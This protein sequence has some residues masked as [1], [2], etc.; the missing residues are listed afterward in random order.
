MADVVGDVADVAA[1]SDVAAADI[2]ATAAAAAIVLAGGRATRL[3]GT[4]KALLRVQGRP[5][6][7]RV[8]DA[9]GEAGR[10]V[11]AI[12]GPPDEIAQ[13]LHGAA[14][15]TAGTAG[16]VRIVGTLERERYGGPAVAVAA[17]AAALADRGVPRNALVDVL[18]CDFV[19]P[20]EVVA[21]LDEACRVAPLGQAAGVVLV[22]DSGREQWLAARVRLGALTAA[23]AGAEADASLRHF[24]A[25]L[26]LRHAP[27]PDGAT[28]D[29]NTPA[30]L[31]AVGA[32]VHVGPGPTCC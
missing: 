25:P 21:A 2:D 1:A 16:D 32:V 26:A 20:R 8:V 9:L 15:A 22:D 27:A 11:V 14:A 18:A 4:S 13:A 19:R 6:L 30:D 31:A 3:G 28:R 5:A 7:A 23:L 24:L 12:V 17:G 10:T 29:L